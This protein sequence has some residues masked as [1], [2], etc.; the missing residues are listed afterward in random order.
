MAFALSH[1]KKLSD[2]VKAVAIAE[3]EEA[4]NILTK[5]PNGL[6]EAV[7]DTRK[8][9]KRVRGLYRLVRFGARGFARKE[10]ARIR[11]MAASLSAERDATA[12]LECVDFLRAAGSDGRTDSALAK[13]E[14]ALARRRALHAAPD[15]QLHG[16]VKAAVVTCRAAINAVSSLRIDNDDAIRVITR[17][18]EKALLDAQVALMAAQ[19]TG[20]EEDFHELR[21][22]SQ[23][24]WMF[25]A[26]M[27]PLWPSAMKAKADDAKALAGLLGNEHDLSVLIALLDSREALDIKPDAR[28]VASAT[29]LTTRKRLRKQAIRQGKRIFADDAKDEAR[30]IKA[31]WLANT[32]KQA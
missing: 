13:L 23:D 25:C 24:Y 30:A 10:N 26:L 27:S 29:A 6:H 15:V 11:T 18:W 16:K 2:A 7:H 28:K 14:V 31:L 12:L 1:Q 32:G 21:K 5:Q 22:R 17:G 4:V 19:A 9:F 3:L 20:L 8:K